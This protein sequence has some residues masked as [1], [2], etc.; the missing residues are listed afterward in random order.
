MLWIALSPHEA[1][2]SHG[3]H[4]APELHERPVPYL[5]GHLSDTVGALDRQALAWR[6]LAITPRVAWLDEALILE[7][8]A[9]LRLWGGLNGL[10]LQFFESNRLFAN[11][12]WAHGATSLVAIGRL[13]DGVM[14]FDGGHH[15]PLQ[16]PLAALT[17]ARPHLPML[18]RLGLRTWGDL[19]A[20]PRDG[21]ARRFGAALLDAL[22]QA[23]G[24][25]P[26]R[27]PWLRLPDR[28]E[29]RLELPAWAESAP[30]LLFGAQRLLE[31]LCAWLQARQLGALALDLHWRHELRRH[32]GAAL[33]PWGRLAVRSGSACADVRH[34]GRLLDA[35]L[36]RLELAAPVGAL[37]L[38]CSETAALPH[39]GVSLLPS[40][41]EPAAGEEAWAPLLERLSARLGEGFVQ[42]AAPVADHRPEQLAACAPA[43]GVG[44]GGRPEADRGTHRG[45][46][47]ATSPMAAWYPT[48]LLPQ[49][50]P[51]AQQ[52]E[53]P[54]YH[55]PLQLLAGPQRIET[56]WWDGAAALRDYFVARS[57]HAGWVWIFRERPGDPQ[58]QA[59]GPRWFLHGWYG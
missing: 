22:D 25:R 42:R 9:C 14:G 44:P 57:E 46:T 59:G 16:L 36:A 55:G 19:R 6:A 40:A 3:P 20:L 51:L 17:A 18:E 2:Q 38:R 41:T 4:E 52:G 23:L 58:V 31:A 21:V 1:Q 50:L 32:D 56:G 47:A 33:P 28:F 37:R 34:W 39:Q 45:S 26:D 8:S 13:R 7:V 27:H 29:Q 12:R 30:G 11:V 48:W 15:A 54:M 35:H 53:R 49:P 43:T 10:V 5:A 24:E